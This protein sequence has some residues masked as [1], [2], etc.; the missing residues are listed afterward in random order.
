M[1]SISVIIPTL[2]AGLN[3]A[4][5]LNALEEQTREATEIIVVDSESTDDTV[6]I[7]RCYGCKTL[8]V[9]RRDFGHGET[10]TI[11][12]ENAAGDLL[13]YFTQDVVPCNKNAIENLVKDFRDDCV[14]AAFG[15]QV[16]YM[17][18][19]FFARHLRQF[20]YPSNSYERVLGDKESL[21]LKTVFFS[22]SFAAYKREVLKKVDYF[23]SGL[24]F[25]EDTCA[26]ARILLNG[27]R[28]VY[29]AEA[30]V[31]HSHNYTIR[32]DFKRYFDMGVFH[33]NEDWL[34][35]QFGN[36]EDQGVKYIKSEF[37][38]LLKERAF[39]LLPEFV[40]RNIMKFLGYK[41]GMQYANIPEN[42]SRRF[43]M[44]Q[45]WWDKRK[46]S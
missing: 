6:T 40:L 25:G 10:R 38:S 34:L 32:Q 9:S 33:R 15:R 31:F 20:N 18:D 1:H 3:L 37:K 27:Y 29:A 45:V 21:G 46:T 12:A 14:G 35:K 28:I 42:I 24:I 7:S 30:S 17:S 13:V 22:N 2:N 11:A 4:A 16:A 43:S 5:L 19:S 36:A 44:N 39:G 41:L 23:Q 26:A 8:N